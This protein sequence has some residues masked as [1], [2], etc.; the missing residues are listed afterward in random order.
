MNTSTLERKGTWLAVVSGLLYGLLGYFGVTLMSLGFSEGN[1]GWWR[2]I[3]SSL[4]LLLIIFARRESVIVSRDSLRALINGALFYT[5]PS[6]LFFIASKYIGTGQ[7]MVIFFIYPAFVMIFNCLFEKAAFRVHYI[8]SFLM[9]IVGLLFLVD[10]REFGF[11]VMGIG[12]SLLSAFSYACY[13]VSSKRVQLP[14]LQSTLMVS[15]GCALMS[16]IVAIV[17]GTLMWPT[18]FA[19]WFNVVALGI[20]CSAVPI[21]LLLEA[22]KY[23]STEKASLLSVLEPVATVIFGV[24]LLGEPLGVGTVFG[25]LLILLGAMSVTFDWRQLSFTRVFYG[26]RKSRPHS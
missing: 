1:I 9:I 13:I 10:V 2:F 14:A 24:M 11:D 8:L 6:I 7:S 4:F 3:S 22:M 21:L 25:I 12:A 5:G 19:Q 15:V 17:D 20:I 23:I 26:S 16:G 18:E